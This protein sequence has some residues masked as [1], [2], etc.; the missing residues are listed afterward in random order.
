[1]IDVPTGIETGGTAAFPSWPQDAE[2]I[3][4]K[5]RNY[6][7]PLK[8]ILK[9]KNEHLLLPIWLKHYESFLHYGEIIIADNG[10]TDSRVLELYKAL[11]PRITLF[12]YSADRNS[13]FH[14]IIHSR[15]HFAGLYKA[16]SD[17]STHHVFVDSDELLIF[18]TADQ[19]SQDR[20]VLVEEMSRN[21]GKAVATAWLETCPGSTDIVYVGS[22]DNR[23]RNALAWGKP[24]VPAH[25]FQTGFPIHNGQFAQEAFSQPEG[26]LFVLLHLKN[27]SREQRLTAN[28][29]KLVARGIVQSRMPFEDIAE[30]DVMMM[31]DPTAV[32][33]IREIRDLLASPKVG[34]TSGMP[35]GSIKFDSSRRILFSDDLTRNLFTKAFADLAQLQRG[36]FEIARRTL[37]A[38]DQEGSRTETAQDWTEAAA[39]LEPA[40]AALKGGATAQGEALLEEGMRRFPAYL[41]RFGD[42]AF[43]KERVR[44][45][46]A[47]KR[48]SEAEAVVTEGEGIGTAGWHHIL[49][50][51]ALDAAGRMD[52]GREHW[53][54]FL[55]TRPWH[56]EARAALAGMSLSAYEARRQS[57]ARLPAPF[58]QILERVPGQRL[59]VLFDVG[60]N[61]GQSCLLYRRLF[62]D[63]VIHAF[64]PVPA[65]HLKLAQAVAGTNNIH[66]HN[67][68]LSA[69]DGVMAMHP[70]EWSTMNRLAE[71]GQSDGTEQVVTRRLDSFCCEHGIRHIDF[72]K[73]DTE[74]HDLTVLEG[75]GDFLRD[76]D[77]IQCEASANRYN[78][79]HVPFAKVFDFLSDAGFHLFHIDGLTYEG[80]NGGYPVLR[81]FD[82]V[83]INAR[84]VGR[85]RN[86]VDR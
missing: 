84:I 37:G 44:H 52:E 80:G 28:R 32:R 21:S 31:R 69:S 56:P 10:S 66:V 46:L 58:R 72:L 4:A 36:G 55:E 18:V 59:A 1:M 73:V 22:D 45:L 82:P 38:A 34:G 13:G 76:I 5:I 68:A 43:R 74:G 78:R 62:P 77:F 2:A 12:S 35:P 54:A 30:L 71:S 16:L 39:L 64:E 7:A 23:L 27:Y 85:I 83:F 75:A 9:T 33:L 67:V 25:L 50:A 14:N 81:R 61:V 63:A 51:R 42:P 40:L 24:I 17:S 6:K 20:P 70:A 57:A 53:T 11:D 19:W 86:V 26:G 60:A 8:V 79:F 49:Y 3:C 15:Q 47:A 65:T 29:E 48:W 41:D